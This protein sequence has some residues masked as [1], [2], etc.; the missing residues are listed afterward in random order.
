MDRANNLETKNNKNKTR[1]KI[2]EFIIGTGI[3]ASLIAGCS[4]EVQG[5]AVPETTSVA[6][7][8]TPER[9]A[10]GADELGKLMTDYT[11]GVASMLDT[12]TPPTDSA[13][14][15]PEAYTTV[16]FE[17]R[18]QPQS[19]QPHP[20]LEKYIIGGVVHGEQTPNPHTLL[21]DIVHGNLDTISGSKVPTAEPE[22][23]DEG[24]II[25][26]E[27]Y[28]P[29]SVPAG[30]TQVDLYLLREQT[31][32]DGRTVQA[33]LPCGVMKQTDGPIAAGQSW[34]SVRPAEAGGKDVLPT[35][36]PTFYTTI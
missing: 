13:L 35:A 9:R 26:S 32:S 23:Q 10:L 15:Y 30:S 5:V 12:H 33:I 25:G 6:P 2:A 19:G 29:K 22:P 1:S 34:S 24:I 18:L 3:A 7:A 14:L 4:Q 21:D 11:C 31:A 36:I 8:T 28:V 27:L 16:Q 20:P 17:V